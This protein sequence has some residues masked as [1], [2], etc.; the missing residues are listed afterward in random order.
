V[1]RI[2]GL[3][4]QEETYIEVD[5]DAHWQVHAAQLHSRC[6]WSPWEGAVL[7]GRVRRTVLRGRE[8]F[9]DGTVISPPGSGRILSPQTLETELEE[10]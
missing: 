6:G 1:A 7:R 8:A 10:A 5:P 9:L 4:P 3:A 2:F